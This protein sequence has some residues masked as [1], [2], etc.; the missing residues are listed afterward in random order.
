MDPQE[1]LERALA[2]CSDRID[3]SEVMNERDL[4]F[5]IGGVIHKTGMNVH[6]DCEL[7]VCFP[8]MAGKV[9]RLKKRLGKENIYPDIVVTTRPWKDVKVVDAAIEVKRMGSGAR[10]GHMKWQSDQD[11]IRSDFARLKKLKAAGLCKSAFFALRF[12]QCPEC[13]PL[14]ERIAGDPV[15]SVISRGHNLQIYRI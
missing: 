4:S 6:F 10:P 13:Y 3:D 8:K 5:F 14:M 15:K 11:N 12:D 7:A 1:K 2:R 9:N